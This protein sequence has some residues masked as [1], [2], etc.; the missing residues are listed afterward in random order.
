MERGS[1]N[2][3]LAVSLDIQ[4]I[5]DNILI[6]VTMAVYIVYGSSWLFICMVQTPFLTP[7]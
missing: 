3:C 2:R 6:V 5:E 1:Q 4:Y 7:N